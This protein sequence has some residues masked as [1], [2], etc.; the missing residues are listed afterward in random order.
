MAAHS[1]SSPEGA[2]AEKCI[3][4]RRGTAGGSFIAFQNR[5]KPESIMNRAGQA[6]QHRLEP[7]S[8]TIL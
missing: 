2:V 4:S 1:R 3:A 6:Y 8:R 7:S 5:F